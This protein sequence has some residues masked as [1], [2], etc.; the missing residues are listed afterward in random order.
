MIFTLFKFFVLLLF[1][2][3]KAIFALIDYYLLHIKV[4]HLPYPERLRRVF[5]ENLEAE[6]VLFLSSE[7]WED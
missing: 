2:H 7:F 3:L 4:S 1:Y 6:S 5:R